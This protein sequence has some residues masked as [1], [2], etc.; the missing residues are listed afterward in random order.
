MCSSSAPYSW[1]LASF[2]ADKKERNETDQLIITL[3]L[4]AVS[5]TCQYEH[6]AVNTV[7]TVRKEEFT[8]MMAGEQTQRSIGGG[9][10]PPAQCLLPTESASFLL[11][12]QS[13]LQ[14]HDHSDAS[15]GMVA[16]TLPPRRVDHTYRDFS[17]FPLDEL[18]TRK[19]TPTN[20]PSKL[21][22]ILSNPEY[23]HVSRSI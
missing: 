3:S 16:P 2:L 14:Y 8:T 20:F 17:N 11:N 22:Q 10:Y 6:D 4:Y 19:R 23:A 9:G 5:S 12:S 15:A 21:H 1:Y 18:P 7:F 13:S